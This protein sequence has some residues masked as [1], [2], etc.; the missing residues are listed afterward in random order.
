MCKGDVSQSNLVWRGW[1]RVSPGDMQWPSSIG[2][3]THY[4]HRTF[5]HLSRVLENLGAFPPKTKLAKWEKLLKSVHFYLAYLLGLFLI[6][7]ANWI[8]GSIQYW[9]RRHISTNL[10]HFTPDAMVTVSYGLNRLSDFAATRSVGVIRKAKSA[11][12]INEVIFTSSDCVIKGWVIFFSSPW[13]FKCSI[14]GGWVE[15]NKNVKENAIVDQIHCYGPIAVMRKLIADLV[16]LFF[17]VKWW[18]N[19]VG[20]LLEKWTHGPCC[21]IS[22]SRKKW[23]VFILLTVKMKGVDCF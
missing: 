5:T 20:G 14:N 16:F 7:G 11:R 6:F 12:V 22:F 18:Q 3:R 13:Q 23:N 19:I 1:W 2:L 17:S 9:K 8:Q 10:F 4:H 15:G 21:Q